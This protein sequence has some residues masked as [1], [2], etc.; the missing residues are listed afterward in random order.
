MSP[1]NCIKKF[2]KNL[3]QNLSV[4]YFEVSDYLEGIIFLTAGA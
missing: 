3:L 1:E 2:G 4:K